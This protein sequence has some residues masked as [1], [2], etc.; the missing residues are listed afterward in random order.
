MNPYCRYPETCGKTIEEIEE[1]FSKGG[2]YPWQTKKGHS[3]LDR[4]IEE[5]REKHLQIKDVA[6]VPLH[7][8]TVEEKSIEATA[9]NV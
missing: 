5:A 4:M 1:M 9:A 7:A 3:K 6:G 2:P 8:E